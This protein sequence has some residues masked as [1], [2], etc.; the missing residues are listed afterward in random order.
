MENDLPIYSGKPTVYLDQNVLDL[1]VKNGPDSFENQLK[2]KFQIVYSDETLKEIKRAGEGANQFLD[3]L[4]RLDAHHLKLALQFPYFKDTGKANLTYRDPYDAFKDLCETSTAFGNIESAMEQSVFKFSGGRQGDTFSGIHNEQKQAFNQLLENTLSELSG[5]PEVT[6]EL[7]HLFSEASHYMQIELAKALDQSELLLQNSIQDE[8]V[9]SGIK[10]F[11]NKTK[12]GPRELNN[13][14]PPNVL[15]KICDSYK[16]K[17]G[18]NEHNFSV[19]EFFG[20]A[21]NYADSAQPLYMHQKVLMIYNML[22]T[23]GYFPDSKVHVER[24]FISS[25][26]D[27][28]HAS[29]AS[30]CDVLVSGDQAFVKKTQA[31]YEYLGIPTLIYSLMPEL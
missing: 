13:I 2:S 30:F 10:D 22:N 11:R 23:V 7:L 12:V 5:I 21:K 14:E 18:F 6:P 20:I 31:A 3:V 4:K 9:W 28:N 16:D 17:E 24:R 8:K 25:M 15:Q 27:T 29:M 26:S 1:F 19:E